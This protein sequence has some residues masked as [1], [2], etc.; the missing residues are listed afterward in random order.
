MAKQMTQEDRRRIDHLLA[1]GMTINDIATDRGRNKTMVLHEIIARSVPCERGYG[2]SN[3]LCAKFESC[4]RIKGYGGN[5]KRLFRCKPGCFK[6]CPEFIERTARADASGSPLR[7]AT[8]A[9]ASATVR[10]TSA[11]TTWTTP[12]QTGRANCTSLD[13]GSIRTTRRSYSNGTE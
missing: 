9:S 1:V 10:C 3:T 7:C 2:C 11:S 13:A 8:A 5:P 4:I 12:R 6:A